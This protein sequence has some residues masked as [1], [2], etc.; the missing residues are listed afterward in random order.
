[1]NCDQCEML[2]INGMA[3]HETGCP[4]ARREAI[5]IIAQNNAAMFDDMQGDGD[6]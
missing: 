3:C 2:S 6:I 4:N 5:A 1:M